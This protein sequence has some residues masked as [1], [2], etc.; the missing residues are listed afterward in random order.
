MKWPAIYIKNIA[1]DFREM[2]ASAEHRSSFFETCVTSY[3]PREILQSH[4]AICK[5]KWID[6][7]DYLTLTPYDE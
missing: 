2:A 5:P 1:L 6:I 4:D 7:L 3:T